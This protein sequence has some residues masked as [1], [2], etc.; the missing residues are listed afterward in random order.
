MRSAFRGGSKLPLFTK[1]SSEE[2]FIYISIRLSSVPCTIYTI[3]DTSCNSRNAH[4]QYHFTGT[5][6]DQHFFYG[7]RKPSLVNIAGHLQFATVNSLYQFSGPFLRF[8]IQYVYKQFIMSHFLTGIVTSSYDY[9]SIFT[10]CKFILFQL[11]NCCSLSTFLKIFLFLQYFFT[12]Q[13]LLQHFKACTISLNSIF[14]IKLLH[15]TSPL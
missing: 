10:L 3:R 13:L 14:M 15:K 4:L 2:G 9:T 11:M 12:F 8:Y 1:T 6:A 5:F 7:F